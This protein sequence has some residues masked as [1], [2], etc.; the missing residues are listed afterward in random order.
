MFRFG[1]PQ[2]PLVPNQEKLDGRLEVYKECFHLC[3]TSSHL[4]N[5]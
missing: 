4:Q 2:L 1:E 3:I 5:V